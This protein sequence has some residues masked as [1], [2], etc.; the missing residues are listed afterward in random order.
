MGFWIFMLIINLLIPLS[1]IG[2]G[3]AFSKKPPQDINYVVGYRTSMSM[4]NKETWE[5]AHQYF[6]KLWFRWGIIVLPIT[7]IA[8]CFIIGEDMDTIGKIGVYI[9]LAQ[10]LPLIGPIFPTELALRRTF[11][12]NGARKPNS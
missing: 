5:F 2:I 3:Y 12:K 1:M 4:V 10:M 8:M 11:D 9:C 7:I 6:G